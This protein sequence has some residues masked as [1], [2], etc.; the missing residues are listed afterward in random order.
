M[1]KGSLDPLTYRVSRS[2][3]YIQRILFFAEPC[4]GHNFVGLH[5]IRDL[6]ASVPLSCRDLSNDMLKSEIRLVIA[7]P[8]PILDYI[9]HIRN[10]RTWRIYTAY[11]MQRCIYKPALSITHNCLQLLT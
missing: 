10:I 11:M 4:A 5:R 6:K 2:D 3:S 8:E 1:G 9:R 7:Q